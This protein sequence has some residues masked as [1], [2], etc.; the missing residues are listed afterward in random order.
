MPF[1]SAGNSGSASVQPSGSRRCDIRS[2]SA[3]PSGLLCGPGGEGLLPLGVRGPAAVDDRRGRA[4]APR[5]RRRR[6][7]RGRSR[8]SSW[9]PSTS[10]SPSA[11]PWALPVFCALGAGQAMTVRSEMNDGRSV[12][13]QR[14]VEGRGERLHVLGVLSAVAEPVDALDVPAVGLV[15][16]ARRPRTARSSCRPRSRCG[17]RRRAGRG[18]R[19]AASPASEDASLRDAL[20]DVAVGG[21]APDGVVERALAG[22]GVGVEAGRARGG[23]PSPC[24][25]RCRRPGRAARWSSRRRRC[26]RARGAPG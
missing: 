5:G 24:R 8:E 26:G 12:L 19:A 25:R 20:L 22:R 9:W 18:C 16:G 11:L 17:C 2:S 6:S 14:G 23:R 7:A 4:P 3:L 10:S 1:A 15:A 21:E 13:G